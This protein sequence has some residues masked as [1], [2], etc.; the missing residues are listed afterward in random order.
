MKIGIEVELNGCWNT[1]NQIADN[2]KLS[3]TSFKE[4]WNL[5]VKMSP[6]YYPE[7]I[8]YNFYPFDYTEWLIEEVT[9]Y[10][11]WQ[12]NKYEFK[13]NWYQPAFVWTHIHF[14]DKKRMPKKRLLNWVMSF[15]LE[16]IDKISKDWLY[17]LIKW[18]QLWG[19]WSHRNSHIWRDTICNREFH[20]EIY[21]WTSSKNK[22]SPVFSSRATPEWKPASLEI[23]IIPNDFFFNW[24]IIDFLDEIETK[25]IFKR[26]EVNPVDFFNKL[27][28]KFLELNNNNWR[29]GTNIEV[30]F[31]NFMSTEGNSLSFEEL[32]NRYNLVFDDENN[33][34]IVKY[35][36][37]N[38]NFKDI[39][40]PSAFLSFINFGDIKRLSTLWAYESYFL[41]NIWTLEW[42]NEII[43]LIKN[44]FS[45]EF[46]SYSYINNNNNIN[47]NP[48]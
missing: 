30:S 34:A 29:R 35:I 7:T 5:W 22:Y 4:I 47:T 23:R 37:D 43:D 48:F 6:E 45:W 40:F 24:T 25:E 32:K 10:L 17:R 28:D 3:F 12:I 36:D 20:P 41:R 18:H 2:E 31:D 1:Y 42:Y 9:K 38:N 19:Y 44:K 11:D 14:F 8:E 26:E 15:I 27:I 13:I 39:I 16:N 21:D 33:I 46:V